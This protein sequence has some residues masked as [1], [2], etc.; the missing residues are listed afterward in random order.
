MKLLKPNK[1]PGAVSTRVTKKYKKLFLLIE[2]LENHNL[3]P[4]TESAVN[5]IIT[6]YNAYN[7]PAEKLGRTIGKARVD[8]L[9]VVEKNMKLIPKNAM[10]IRW[11]GIGMSAFGIS[12]GAA[13][14]VV[15]GNM[16]FMGVGIGIGLSIGVAIGAGLDNKAKKENRQLN[17]EL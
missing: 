4:D 17:I 9:R 11:M 15:L 6:N 16:A 3:T 13:Y 14:F 10:L 12:L 2:E 5:T 8:I 1:L 7:G